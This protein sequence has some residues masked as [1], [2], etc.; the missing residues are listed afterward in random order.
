M[1]WIKEASFILDHFEHASWH[2]FVTDSLSLVMIAFFKQYVVK[3][4][5]SFKKNQST[6]TYPHDEQGLKVSLKMTHL[7]H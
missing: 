1:L 4:W 2:L 3:M 7:A 5:L 6:G